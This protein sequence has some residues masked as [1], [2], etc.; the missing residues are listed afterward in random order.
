[1]PA[2]RPKKEQ[3]PA[4]GDAPVTPPPV[5]KVVGMLPFDEVAVALGLTKKALREGLEAE[6]FAHARI[7]DATYVLASPPLPSAPMVSMEF[8][9]GQILATLME[10][11]SATERIA[12]TLSALAAPPVPSAAAAPAPQPTGTYG[13]Q[14]DAQVE[15]AIARIE[16]AEGDWGLFS[17]F[18]HPELAP[19]PD[20]IY[21]HLRLTGDAEIREYDV[22][23]AIP[24]RAVATLEA[25]RA[26]YGSRAEAQRAAEYAGGYQENAAASRYDSLPVTQLTPSAPFTEEQQRV[27]E[28]HLSVLSLDERV[29]EFLPACVKWERAWEDVHTDLVHKI[30]DDAN[31]RF[32]VRDASRRVAERALALVKRVDEDIP[33]EPALPTG[34]VREQKELQQVG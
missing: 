5:V 15:R 6:A 20:V 14:V 18:L 25:I 4:A 3:E 19:L 28:G 31:Y 24:S 8:I 22:Q 17:Q 33:Q 29:E 32:R 7:G 27:L 12:A 2:G 11:T 30:G 1:M 16:N 23:L 9:G 10:L 34:S 13:E 21:N 26:K